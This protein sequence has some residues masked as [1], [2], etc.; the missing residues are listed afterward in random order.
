MSDLSPTS[1]KEES[2]DANLTRHGAP[3]VE[4]SKGS[5]NFDAMR[6]AELGYTQ[7]MERK[8]SVLSLVFAAFS[9]TNSWFGL[10]AAMV[11]G[12]N[13]GGPSGIIYGVI[14]MAL[15]S[16]CTAISLSELA[17]ALPS[18]GGQYYWASELAPPRYAKFASY[19]TGWFS[20]A[21]SIFTSASTALSVGFALVGCYQLS[22][23]DL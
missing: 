19:L 20:W 8:F 13:S 17:S 16:T 4:V 21:G 7:D 3:D 10:S 23:P 14:L 2:I 6:L 22:H 5:L 11:T 9:L 18:A 12:I 15:I 1:S